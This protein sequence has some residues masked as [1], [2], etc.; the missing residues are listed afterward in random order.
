MDPRLGEALLT[1]AQTARSVHR[2]PRIRR[3]PRAWRTHRVLALQ[4]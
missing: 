3:I 4:V 2:A 1:A